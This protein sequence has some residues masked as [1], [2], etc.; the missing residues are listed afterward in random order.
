LGSFAL[1]AKLHTI[2]GARLERKGG[3]RGLWRYAGGGL[4]TAPLFNATNVWSFAVWQNSEAEQ[5]NACS[6]PLENF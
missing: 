4:E 5:A 1:G 2:R 6:A 3:G